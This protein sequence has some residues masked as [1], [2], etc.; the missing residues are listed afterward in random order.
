MR[1]PNISFFRAINVQKYGLPLSSAAAITAYISPHVLALRT[2]SLSPSTSAFTILE[3]ARHFDKVGRIF[4]LIKLGHSK[5]EKE[6]FY[7]QS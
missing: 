7:A 1:R 4:L 3:M 6:F 5:R 2:L